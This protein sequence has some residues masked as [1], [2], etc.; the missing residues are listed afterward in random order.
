MLRKPGGYRKPTE[1]QRRR[2]KLSKE[3]HAKWF[4]AIWHD[5]SGTSTKDHPAPF[6][7]ELAYRL[8]RMFS[9]V[10]DTVLDPFLGTGST[11]LAACGRS[12][13]ALGMS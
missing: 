10:D 12:G 7:L 9:F 6:S 4:R 11:M 5:V 2:S 1:D 13:I 8:V 3:E